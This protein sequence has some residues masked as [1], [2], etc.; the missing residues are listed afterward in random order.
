MDKMEQDSFHSLQ[1]TKSNPQNNKQP[2]VF[3][4]WTSNDREKYERSKR[5]YKE[6]IVEKQFNYST[7][8]LNEQEIKARQNAILQQCLMSE[9]ECWVQEKIEQKRRGLA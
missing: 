1:D 4:K 6:D 3:W 2:F 5:L 8:S 9:E 7:F